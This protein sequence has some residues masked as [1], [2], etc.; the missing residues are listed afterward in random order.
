MPVNSFREDEKSIE[1][2]KAKT[3]LRLFS[4]L[5]A[6]KKEILFVLLLM[7]C[8]VGVTLINPLMIETAIDDH[9]GS[10]DYPG[11]LR[12]IAAAVFLNLTMV[13]FIKLRM[14]IMNQVCNSIL[15][16]IRQEL[17]THIQT[18][19]FHFFDS[20]PTGKIL[21]RIIGDINS[22][23][24]VLGNCVTTLIPDFITICCVVAIMLAK[25]PALTAASLC[26]L[27]VMASG[28]W[29]I[30][31]LSHKRWQ[32]FRKK[33]ANLNA[34]VHEDLSGMR[35]IQSF[36][37]QE[38]TNK[39][40]LRLV[41]E[42]RT[43]YNS[44]VRINDAMGSVIDLCWG[45]GCAALYYMGIVVI[46]VEQ[47]SVGT[48]LAFGSYINM[49][50][51]PIM[52][53][54]NFYTQIITNL[55]AAERI[56]EILDTPS[57]I[58]DEA[59]AVEMPPIAG[60]VTFDHVTF[61]YSDAPGVN[62]LQNVS[63]HIHPGETIALVGPTGA[64][65][66][67]IVNLISRF[68][69]ASGGRVLIDGQDVRRVTLESLR[70]Q[71]GIMTQDNF[72]F[73]GTVRENIRYGRL[74]ATDEEIESAAKAVNAHEFIMKLEKGY[75]TQ[76]SERGGGLSVGQ[77]QLLAFARTFLSMPRILILDEAT[78]SIDTKTE[79]LVQQ[80][81]DTLLKGRTSFVIAHRLST[82]QKADRI[83]VI[84][85]GGIL[86]EG[87]AKELLAKKGAYYRLYMAQFAL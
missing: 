8:C 42:H 45:V 46:G 50:W 38:E 13:L 31:V 26:S 27:P 21:S 39:T 43:A 79:L 44:A 84:D 60:S 23:K 74:D 10:G 76:L 11:L 14:R 68:Y 20:R 3:L 41:E 30:Q 73:S 57:E 83:F 35:I 87:T 48:L 56:F 17:Y 81:I 19:D 25:S 33:S 53:L 67:T 34:F 55:A 7:A 18:L 5:L 37:A 24:D 82:I 1:A 2:G 78:S 4:Y 85:Q 49:F 16:E 65:K 77:R 72:L 51:R 63:F 6:Y 80:G 54:S 32:I 52:N 15:M 28:M 69:N 64:G 71:M 59:D 61:A 12:L 9:I 58:T 29:F 40:F 62:V 86:E 75:D 22:L 70:S 66:T 47:I 36:T